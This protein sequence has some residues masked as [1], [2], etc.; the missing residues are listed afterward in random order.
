MPSGSSCNISSSL[1][2]QTLELPTP[3]PTG[4]SLLKQ[5]S[6]HTHHTG[7]VS[8]ENPDEHHHIAK[9]MT[10]N[11]YICMSRS[12]SPGLVW[13]CIIIRGPGY[14]RLAI[15]RSLVCHLMVHPSCLTSRYPVSFL[16]AKRARETRGTPPELRNTF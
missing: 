2:L 8:L 1:G 10:D 9:K 11:R 13:C 3:T 6:I 16:P 5:I 4:A 14:F 7:S 12:G 15:P